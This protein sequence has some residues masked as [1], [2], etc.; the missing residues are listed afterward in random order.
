[1]LSESRVGAIT[2]QCAGTMALSGALNKLLTVQEF[3]VSQAL[4]SQQAENFA[5]ELAGLRQAAAQVS[6][7]TL[8]VLH[9]LRSTRFLR[10]SGVS[11]TGPEVDFKDQ[12][13]K[14]FLI[15]HF[16]PRVDSA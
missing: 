8:F 1:M 4:T 9:A 15:W 16:R 5:V 6:D 3:L 13:S 10:H 12:H 11:I 7:P 14:A 2:V